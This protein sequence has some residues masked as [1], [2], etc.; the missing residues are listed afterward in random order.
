MTTITTKQLRENMQEVVRELSQGKAI[1]LSYRRRV[2]GVI[3]PQPV[4]P[5]PVRRGS[6]QAVVQGLQGL[7]NISIPE[8]LQNDPRSIKEQLA[9]MRN[10]QYQS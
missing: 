6:P 8:K 9:D 1:Q 5:Q 2:I 7:K 3:Q 4:S 10:N